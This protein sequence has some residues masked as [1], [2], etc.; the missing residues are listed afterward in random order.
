[1]KTMT[2]IVNNTV[3]DMDHPAHA[4]HL[5]ESLRNNRFAIIK[6]HSIFLDDL[7]QLYQEWEI[8]FSKDIAEKKEYLYSMESDDGYVPS[9]LEHAKDT[10]KPDLKEF[11]QIHLD[12]LIN[13]KTP[14]S[15]QSKKIFYELAQLGEYL[16]KSI[17]EQL[18]KAVKSSMLMPLWQ[19]VKE[20]R[21]HCM[22]FIHY[23]PCGD[24]TELY[25]S[26]PHDD[27]CLL[28]IIIP[29]KGEGL[30]MKKNNGWQQENPEEKVLVV[31]NSEMLEM[32]TE[33]YL[34]SM[35]HQVTTD[36]TENA[37]FVS[38]Y[39]MPFFVHPHSNMLLNANLTSYAAV[40]QR[41]IETGLDKLK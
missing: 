26:A 38:R 24:S 29:T 11:Y 22:R 35:T 18:P 39:S 25:R 41:I 28:T 19:S 3:V 17:D 31:F 1:M 5:I 32:C 21:R 36:L 34:K 27:I 13:Q 8:F 6:N 16:I 33:G 7:S 10:D 40:K 9:N 15:E 12:G 23:P 37:R 20:S 14:C 2:E 4:Q 30:I